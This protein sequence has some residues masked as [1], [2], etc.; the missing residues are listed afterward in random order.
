MAWASWVS[1]MKV[2][3]A[4]APRETLEVQRMRLA[5]LV[6]Q[7]ITGSNPSDLEV[8]S[9][10]GE[11]VERIQGVGDQHCPVVFLLRGHPHFTRAGRPCN[12]PPATT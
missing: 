3:V 5:K 8:G 10:G 9:I 11:H 7:S 1:K 2:S 12:E 4:W 6:G